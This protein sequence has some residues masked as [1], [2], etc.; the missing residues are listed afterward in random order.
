MVKTFDASDVLFDD[1]VITFDG[2]SLSPVTN[3][4]DLYYNEYYLYSQK[5]WE[6][7]PAGCI[8][9]ALAS[10]VMQN[11]PV[12]VT[13]SGLQTTDPLDPWAQT[14][15]LGKYSKVGYGYFTLIS[16]GQPDPGKREFA[17]HPDASG[18][19]VFNSPLLENVF[20]EYEASPSGYYILDTLDLNP[21]RNKVESG[22]IHM[23]I[24]TEP[25]S[26][27]LSA[28][29]STLVADGV[30]FTRIVATLYDSNSDTIP[31][32]NVIFYIPDDFLGQLEPTYGTGIQVGP[33]GHFIKIRETTDSKGRARVKYTSIN[34]Q[35]GTQVIKAYYEQDPLVANYISIVQ[36]YLVENP[37]ILDVSLLDSL[38]YLA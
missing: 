5:R 24:S 17:L 12:V 26:I 31:D 28:T 10:G 29:H 22:F 14:N 34:T 20:I 19:L 37:F 33:S 16:P 3:L 38:D 7:A 35:S 25:A 2:Y 30:H 13:A 8:E 27:F 21:I 36:T 9:Y 15:G 11:A 6:M 23:S 18:K 32:E 4:G 1:L